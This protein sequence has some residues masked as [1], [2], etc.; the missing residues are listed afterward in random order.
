[1]LKDVAANERG[2]LIALQAGDNLAVVLAWPSRDTAAN[3]RYPER[4]ILGVALGVAVVVSIDL[5][6]L[7][8]T[9][10]VVFDGPGVEGKRLFNPAKLKGKGLFA[11]LKRTFKQYSED[12]VSDW[13]AAL[14]YYGLLSLFP[15][16]IALVSLIGLVADPAT[17]TQKITQI[18]TSLG[19]S[20]A[21]DTFAGPIKSIT[22]NKSAASA[23]FTPCALQIA[24]IL[25]TRSRMAG[26]AGS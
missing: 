16:L 10:N 5:A 3:L 17:V 21:A 22:S 18:V 9:F 8:L 1:M 25:P 14:T 20:S 2:T 19:P 6:T 23:S 12:N 24:W 11:A 13:A 15:A 4:K 7:E 26:G